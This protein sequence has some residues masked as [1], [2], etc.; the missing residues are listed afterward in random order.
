MLHGAAQHRQEHRGGEAT[1]EA[2]LA[3]LLY[4]AGGPGPDLLRALKGF[5]TVLVA[6]HG[7]HDQPVGICR[8]TPPGATM[9]RIADA[10]A[11]DPMDDQLKA[12]YAL[13]LGVRRLSALAVEPG[14]RGAGLGRALLQLATRMTVQLGAQ[15]LYGHVRTAE[16][17][18][19]W[20]REAGFTVLA[21][22]QGLSL[23]WLIHPSA[24]VRPGPG[25]HLI[26]R[27]ADPP[28]PAPFLDRGRRVGG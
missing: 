16:N 21:P 14:H 11:D 8:T 22:G 20:Y 1:I 15:V 6:T 4:P 27:M 26:V 17:L 2:A 28:T 24:S 5:S 10:M 12:Q 18:A 13:L 25:E 3:S 23:A 19:D 9:R 7:P